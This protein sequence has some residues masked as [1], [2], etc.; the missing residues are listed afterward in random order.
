MK[1]KIEHLP[2]GRVWESKE[3]CKSDFDSFKNFISK[4]INGLEKFYV[5]TNEGMIY[6][7][8]N[9]LKDSV[10]NFIG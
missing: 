10:F 5:E 6:L 9:I 4:N 2:S 3:I 1:I 8:G 7:N